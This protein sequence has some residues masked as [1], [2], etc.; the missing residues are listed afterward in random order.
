MKPEPPK[1]LLATEH[2][3]E[4]KMA[5]QRKE[6]KDWIDRLIDRHNEAL[7]QQTNLIRQE[8]KEQMRWIIGIGFAMTFAVFSALIAVLVKL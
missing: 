4:I 5:E 1:V 2:Y 8:S 7:I 3:V 6:T